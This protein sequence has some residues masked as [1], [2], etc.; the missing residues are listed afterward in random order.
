MYLNALFDLCYYC[1]LW[2]YE[3]IGELA[4]SF[5]WDPF[6]PVHLDATLFHVLLLLSKHCIQFV[7][8]T[9]QSSPKV[10]GFVTQVDYF[11][12]ILEWHYYGLG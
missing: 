10:I 12:Y 6:F 3:Q 7:P 8:V 11:L 9:E 1:A 4:K 5:L 2:L